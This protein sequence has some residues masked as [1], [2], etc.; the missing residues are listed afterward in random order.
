MAYSLVRHDGS[1]AC[2]SDDNLGRS[3]AR[4]AETRLKGHGD[5]F[6][7]SIDVVACLLAKNLLGI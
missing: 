5:V 6:G 1:P 7:V 4:I 3:G 2:G